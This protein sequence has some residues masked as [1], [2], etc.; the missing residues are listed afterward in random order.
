VHE[1]VG[2]Y[3]AIDPDEHARTAHV[4][5]LWW[6]VL[7]EGVTEAKFLPSDHDFIVNQS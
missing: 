5:C 1:R 7:L 6:C 3:F 4:Q 2:L